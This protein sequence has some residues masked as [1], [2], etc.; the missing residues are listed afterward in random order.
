MM[1]KR[2]LVCALMPEH[3][4][5]SGSRRIL[6]LVDGLH[7]SGWLVTFV[8]QHAHVNPRYVRALERRGI[9]VYAG[10]SK[11][12]DQLIATQH[13]DLA[14]IGLWD[15]AEPYVPR[16]RARSP[17]TRIIVDS[18]DLHFL[19][20]ARQSFQESTGRGATGA[21]DANYARDLIRE[22]NTY[23]AVDGVLAVSGKEAALINDFTGDSTLGYAVP[24]GED[25]LPSALPMNERRGMVFVGCY[26]FAPNVSAAE[27]LCGEILPRLDPKLLAKHPAYLVGDGM[28]D[29]VRGFARTPNTHMVGWVPSVAPYLERARI[30]VVPLLFGAGTKRKVLQ[31]LMYGTPT[32][33]TSIGIEG[34]HLEHNRQVL[35]ADDP[36]SFAD[37]ITR[38]LTDAE[39]WEQLRT[40]GCRHVAGSHG[41]A[42]ARAQLMDAVA[43]V[44]AKTPKAPVVGQV[45]TTP[46]PRVTA[47]EYLQV[48]ERIREAVDASLPAETAVAVVS[49]GDAALLELGSRRARHFPQDETGG[50]AGH[51]PADTA[52]VIAQIDRLRPDTDYLLFPATARWWL[53]HY[54]GLKDHLEERYDLVVDVAE[55]CLIYALRRDADALTGVVELH[56]N[57]P[58][59]DAALD[60]NVRLV[61]FLLPQFHPIPENDRWWGKGF[62]EWTNVTHGRPQFPGHEQPKLPADLGFYDLRL[63][64]VREAQAALARSYGIHG[65][66]Y[67]HYWFSGKQLLERPF[68]EVLRSGEPDFPF[69]LCW[70]NEPWSRRWDGRP[71]AVLQ[72]QAYSHEDD[73]E[74]IRWLLPALT[75]P[76]AIRIDGKPVFLVYQGKDLPDPA[77]TTEIW[78]EEVHKAGL[79]D[80]L[81]LMTVETGWDAGWDATSVGFDA[82]VLFQP[83]FAT[84]F[85]SGAQ[86]AA[87]GD[88]QLR[89]FD[90]QKAWPVLANPEP[91]R[92]P[93]FDTVC[94]SWDNTARV[95]KRAVVMHGSTPDAY[96]QWLETVIARAAGR[97]RDQRIVFLNAWNEWAEGC[98]LEP[99][100]RHGRAYLEATRR[101]LAAFSGAASPKPVG[102]GRVSG[103]NG[104]RIKS[105]A[106]ARPGGRRRGEPAARK[107]REAGTRRRGR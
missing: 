82:K 9:E 69:C 60:A 97:P 6:H 4:R 103:D 90:Y 87:G 94:P 11:W 95:G 24:D 25:L 70:A 22:L 106:S 35:V 89:V 72:P 49:K 47:E 12:M 20:L 42:A 27:Y 33:S 59:I 57:E 50:Y 88:E 32:V 7:D 65:F 36:S 67:Y 30:S 81:Y 54:A 29:T 98:Q 71:K 58:S 43:S 105:L 61:A 31:A 92:Y 79:T 52:Q 102:N 18:I 62:T 38:L 39:L 63:P 46:T 83:Q 76:R 5:D 37:E 93:R 91:V 73:R 8:S 104:G 78:R 16:I 40:E 80:G 85:N 2:A 1:P 84:L 68:N 56:G 41:R 45:L 86:I 53:D 15:I 107:S 19:R 26:R 28:N 100:R 44:M 66:C 3:D 34:L 17:H 77:R 74:H 101:A 13:Y 99:D 55:T 96:Q 10:A 75:D 21:L 64:E 48:V 51:Y 14:A 23:A